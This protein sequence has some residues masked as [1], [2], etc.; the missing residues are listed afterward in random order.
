[1]L[2]IGL[3]TFNEKRDMFVNLSAEKDFVTEGT[4]L[5]ADKLI[6]NY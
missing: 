5:H 1:V 6:A 4:P 2:H 3:R